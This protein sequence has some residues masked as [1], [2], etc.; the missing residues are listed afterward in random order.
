MTHCVESL[1]NSWSL[2]SHGMLSLDKNHFFPSKSAEFC[3]LQQAQR[4]ALSRPQKLGGSTEESSQHHKSS[5][6]W[7][8]SGSSLLP[9]WGKYVPWSM[10]V[11][12]KFLPITIPEQ[13]RQLYGVILSD[14]HCTVPVSNRYSLTSPHP[15]TSLPPVLMH[16]TT[17]MFFYNSVWKGH[18]TPSQLTGRCCSSNCT[19]SCRA[20]LTSPSWLHTPGPAHALVPADS[21]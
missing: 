19:K 4:G 21:P 8:A 14:R 11:Q 15:C 3:Q 12:G 1:S 7:S 5:A 18:E 16:K 17:T 10:R 6:N 9:T 13:T 2:P 20:E